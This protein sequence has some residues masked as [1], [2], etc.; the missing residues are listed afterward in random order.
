MSVREWRTEGIAYGEGTALAGEH[1]GR[2]LALLEAL[3]PGEV[4]RGT[5]S[6]VTDF[7]VFVDIG[8]L[9]GMVSAANLTWRHVRRFSEVAEVGQAVTVVVLDIDRDR[10]RISLSLKDLEPD[11]LI[12]FACT[13]LGADVAGVVETIIPPGVVVRLEAEVYGLVPADDP[14][15]TAR[16]AGGHGFVGGELVDVRVCS[17]NLHRRQVRLRFAAPSG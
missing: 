14:V 1:D 17:I 2:R 6:A 9:D 10:A 16:N 15:L 3:E 7:G 13:R 4:R 8:G 12:A 5:V 11:P